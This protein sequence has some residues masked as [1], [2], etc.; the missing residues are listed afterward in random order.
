MIFGRVLFFNNI[1]SPLAETQSK[2][3]SPSF[4]ICCRTG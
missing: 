1:H 3:K 2:A 4:G